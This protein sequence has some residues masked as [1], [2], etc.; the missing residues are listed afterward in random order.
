MRQSLVWVLPSWSCLFSA[1]TQTVTNI[2]YS[3]ADNV[4]MDKN[5]AG[6]QDRE[7]RG[8]VSACKSGGS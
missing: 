3:I 7:H 4:L 6:K 1:G 2:A 8:A 5:A